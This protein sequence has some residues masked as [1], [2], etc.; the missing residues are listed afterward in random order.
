[1]SG[2]PLAVVQL[3]GPRPWLSG[4]VLAGLRNAV[5]DSSG[6]RVVTV[7]TEPGAQPS[8]PLLAFLRSAGIP[9]VTPGA[10]GGLADGSTGAT[11]PE[12]HTECQATAIRGSVLH[13]ATGRLRV[14]EFTA[15]LLTS[16]AGVA[17]E[18]MGTS[19]PLGTPWDPDELTTWLRE[20]MPLASML[21]AGPGFAGAVTAYRTESGVVEA[22]DVL[23]SRDVLVDR[24]IPLKPRRRPGAG[25]AGRRG[26]CPGGECPGAIHRAALRRGGPERD[27]GGGPLAG[28]GA[29]GFGT[30]PAPGF[31]GG[32]GGGR[33]RGGRAGRRR[34]FPAPG[35]ALP[36]GRR[37]GP[38]PLPGR[39]AADP[40]RGL[41]WMLLCPPTLGSWES[42][43]G[44]E[45]D[46]S[47]CLRKGTTGGRRRSSRTSPKPQEHPD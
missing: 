41:A 9:W 6:Q 24:E 1:M 31:A 42:D 46:H 35:G 8:Y 33:R 26:G 3:A 18:L 15:G 13:E 28:T 45:T 17:P 16:C 19:E 47:F 7:R 4:T 34:T 32:P 36:P 14:G 29:P 40:G 2:V 5:L 44:S 11:L 37:V 43:L 10:E 20:R 39:A 21:L 22:F 30:G 27:G 38:G 12:G 25:P 23:V